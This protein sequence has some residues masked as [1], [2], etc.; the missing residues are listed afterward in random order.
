MSAWMPCA[1]SA[2]ITPMCAAARRAAAQGQAD[3]DLAGRD[4]DRLGRRQYLYGFRG[5]GIAAGQHEGGQGKQGQAFREH[6]G[7]KE[8]HAAKRRAD[9]SASTG[10]VAEAS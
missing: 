4:D 10:A 8:P 9:C 6:S 2:L 3:L 1:S 7:R 5:G